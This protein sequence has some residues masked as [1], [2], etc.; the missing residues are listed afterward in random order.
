[1]EVQFRGENTCGRRR[2]IS[3]SNE[4][5]PPGL[6]PSDSRRRQ[7]HLRGP[8][9]RALACQL[10]QERHGVLASFRKGARSIIRLL[11]INAGS[12]IIRISYAASA[13]VHL[14]SSSQN[15]KRNASLIHSNLAFYCSDPLLRQAH[16]SM[17]DERAMRSGT[18][19]S[20]YCALFE[21]A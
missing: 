16:V 11:P 15:H 3:P 5:L 8:E 17:M 12:A 10:A 21:V 2:G 14:N 20:K 13:R 19:T 6:P 7:G 1:L 18:R 9:I 4:S